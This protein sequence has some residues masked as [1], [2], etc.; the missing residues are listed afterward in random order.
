[1]IATYT[2]RQGDNQEEIEIAVGMGCTQG[3]GSDRYPYRVSAV[4]TPKRIQVQAVQYRRIDQNGQ[5]ESQQYE[6]GDSVGEPITLTRRRNGRWVREGEQQWASPF[7]LGQMD[8]H[9]D[10][11]F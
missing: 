4:L 2:R 10:P 1:M 7:W 8:A 3:V 6:F 5:S 11:H 9:Q